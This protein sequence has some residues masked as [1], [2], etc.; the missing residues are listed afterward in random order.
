MKTHA[1][2]KFHHKTHPYVDHREMKEGKHKSKGIRGHGQ[3]PK[4]QGGHGYLGSS[5][6]PYSIG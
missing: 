5:Q 6:K 4:A 1:Y 2:R 3:A